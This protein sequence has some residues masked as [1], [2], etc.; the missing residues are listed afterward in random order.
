MQCLDVQER[1]SDLLLG[2]ILML[3]FCRF[4]AT[5]F[6]LAIVT[7]LI[8]TFVVYSLMELSPVQV[9]ERCWVRV[10]GLWERQPRNEFYVIRWLIWVS[11]IFL[12]GDLG[13]SCIISPPRQITDLI[14]ARFWISLGICISSLLL[15]YLI[16]IPVGIYSVVSPNIR[17]NHLLRFFSYLGLA[18]PNF[19]FALIILL[20]WS[21]LF[22][23][24]LSG[25]FSREY[26][27][28]EWSIAKFVDFLAHAWLPVLVLGWS[29]TAFALMSVRA[30]VF[31]EYHKLYV[32]AAQARGV[33][34]RQ[35][36]WRYPV[37][38]AMGP[39]VN[40]LGFDLNRV[41]NELP[42]V[43][44]ILSITE[45][46]G[47]LLQALVRSNDQQLAA[48]ILFLLAATIIT[49]NFCTDILLAMLD[50]RFRRSLMG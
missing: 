49:L 39:I 36:L 29:A 38:H 27:S 48:A 46:G 12:H 47:L 44:F 3:L 25:L 31:D 2:P 50:P 16:A 40:S 33:S 15:A 42:I 7:L 10:D 45:A 14:G 22:G 9:F 41:F 1:F 23:E 19:L 5:R 17:F 32:T 43:A 13:S 24:T 4:V 34:G 20:V 37:R 30:L 8:V 35:L 6:L 26:Q 21:I 18:I 28:A 11:D